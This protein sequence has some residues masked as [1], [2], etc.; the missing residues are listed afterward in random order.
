MELSK[1]DL[2]ELQKIIARKIK[3]SWDMD[4]KAWEKAD[5]AVEEF[6]EYLEETC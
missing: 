1:Q 3:E 4:A 5:K 6:I 2:N